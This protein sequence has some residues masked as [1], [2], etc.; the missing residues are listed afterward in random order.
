MIFNYSMTFW[1]FAFLVIV[2]SALA[3]WRQGAIR[4]GILTV[5]I[6]IAAMLAG[7]VGKLAHLVLPH[8]GVQNPIYAWALAPVVGFILLNFVIAAIAQPFHKRAEHFYRYSAGDL[9]QA[10]WERLNS[11]VGICL[12]VLN[13]AMYLVLASFMIFNMAYLT[14]QA[15]TGPQQPLFIRLVNNMGKDMQATGFSRTAAAVATMPAMYYHL[16]DLSGFLIQNPQA[17]GRFADYPAL[18]SLWERNEMQNLVTDAILTNSLTTGTTMT[19]VLKN[20]SVQT[21]LKTPDQSK[22][23]MGILETNYADLTA[24]LQTGESTTYKDKLIGRWQFNPLVTMAWMRQSRPKMAAS[25]MRAIRAWMVQAYAPTRVL[26]TG[27]N[28]IFIKQLPQVKATSPGQPPTTEYNDWKGDW[29]TSGTDYDVHVTA[30]DNNEKFMTA[31]AE[32]LRL[33]IKDGKNML[34]F[35]RVF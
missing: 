11:R 31:S 29:S 9:R 2:A 15:A 20:P 10:L 18:T 32:D 13:G 16:S 8:V 26:A 21:L 1:I 23:V 34:I 25:E 28:Q 7:L 30:G 14:T 12:G 19:E 22:L 3:G 33:T 24:Y 17:A 4:A 6:P 27:D 5:G 35:D